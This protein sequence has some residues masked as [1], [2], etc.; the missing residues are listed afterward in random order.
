M[1][2]KD[3][4]EDNNDMSSAFKLPIA[5]SASATDANFYPLPDEDWYAFYVKSGRTYRAT[6]SNLIAMDT[7]L[8]VFH[9]NGGRVAKNN[10][11]GTRFIWLPLC[12][13][14]WQAH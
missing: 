1:P 4:Y 10:D 3:D 8:E 11:S 13:R 7:Y 14:L 12:F 9:R 6:T 5:V 2:G